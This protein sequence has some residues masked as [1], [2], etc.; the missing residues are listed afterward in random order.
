MDAR[1]WLKRFVVGDLVVDL[2]G[3]KMSVIRRRFSRA[4]LC[5]C[6]DSNSSVSKAYKD[7][8]IMVVKY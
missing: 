5:K 7:D 6:E 3:T 8:K 4:R 2:R 1:C